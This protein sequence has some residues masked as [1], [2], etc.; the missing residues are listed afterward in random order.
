[1]EEYREF[2]HLGAILGKFSDMGGEI[3]ERA[4]QDKSQWVSY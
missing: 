3:K 1:M 2:K 4:V